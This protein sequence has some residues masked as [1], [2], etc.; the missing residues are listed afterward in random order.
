[1]GLHCS[2]TNAHI[3]LGCP[4]PGPSG[5]PPS[6]TSRCGLSPR[7]FR[8]RQAAGAGAVT[9]ATEMSKPR[10]CSFFTNFSRVACVSLVQNCSFRPDALILLSKSSRRVNWTWK[11]SWENQLQPDCC[12]QGH[13]PPYLILD[14]AAQGPVQPVLEYL[15]G[16]SIH[17]L[18]G[19]LFQ[20]LTTLLIK[21]IHLIANLNLPSFNLKPLPLVL[22]SSTL[23]KT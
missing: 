6:C 20:H 12:R 11:R 15:H 10:P 17:S 4:H 18:S 7:S 5:A 14:Q 16:Q 13:K 19:Q 2:I 22:L 8:R 23:S 1:M 21:N 9:S 3:P